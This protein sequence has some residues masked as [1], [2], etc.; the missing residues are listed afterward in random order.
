MM[1]MSCLRRKRPN[2][3]WDARYAL[4]G[5]N[6]GTRRTTPSATRGDYRRATRPLV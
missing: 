3:G 6:T 5:G 2:P 1:R 4:P